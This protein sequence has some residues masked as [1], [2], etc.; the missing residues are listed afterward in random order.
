M[1]MVGVGRVGANVHHNGQN[2]AMMRGLLAQGA[3]TAEYSRNCKEQVR[4]VLWD[5]W[6]HACVWVGW[7][8]LW[9]GVWAGML[10]VLWTGVW[11]GCVRHCCVLVS[12]CVGG[13]VGV[14]WV[15]SNVRHNG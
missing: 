9:T 11:V 13:L 1:R 14:G 4:P 6:G 10:G 3:D 7:G 2:G 15:G 5:W 12:G 8:G